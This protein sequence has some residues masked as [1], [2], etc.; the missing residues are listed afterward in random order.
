MSLG[1]FGTIPVRWD[2][3]GSA[4]NPAGE[5]GNPGAVPKAGNSSPGSLPGSAGVFGLEVTEKVEIWAPTAAERK[6]S[7]DPE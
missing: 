6:P 7:L 5:F 4:G 1:E 2:S 3:D